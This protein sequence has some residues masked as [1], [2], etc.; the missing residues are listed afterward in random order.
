MAGAPRKT[1]TPADD[2]PLPIALTTPIPGRPIAPSLKKPA[3]AAAARVSSF[4]FWEAAYKGDHDALSRLAEAEADRDAPRVAPAEE[5]GNA[6]SAHSLFVSFCAGAHKRMQLWTVLCARKPPQS[7]QT[8]KSPHLPGSRSATVG[9]QASSATPLPFAPHPSASAPAPASTSGPFAASANAAATGFAAASTSQSASLPTR[10]DARTAAKPQLQPFTADELACLWCEEVLVE[11][12]AKEEATRILQAGG[13]LTPEQI[14]SVLSSAQPGTG[15]V[16]GV[17]GGGGGDDDDGERPLQILVHLLWWLQHCPLW[18]DELRALGQGLSAAI[19]SGLELLQR[20]ATIDHE[21]SKVLEEGIALH[22]DLTSAIMLCTRTPLMRRNAALG[23]AGLRPSEALLAEA[24]ACVVRGTCGAPRLDADCASPEPCIHC[25][26]SLAEVETGQAEVEGAQAPP[27]APGKGA[28]PACEGESRPIPPQQAA[29][30]ARVASERVR[31]RRLTLARREMLQ[32]AKAA[33]WELCAVDEGPS[34]LPLLRAVRNAPHVTQLPPA[35]A[36]VARMCREVVVVS[37][38]LDRHFR[39]DAGKVRRLLKLL[40]VKTLVSHL[41][42]KGNADRIAHSA[43]GIMVSV[44]LGRPPGVRLNMAQ[45]VAMN[46]P[47][48]QM[49]V[50]RSK[51]TLDA[52]PRHT[53]RAVE[54]VL[55]AKPLLQCSAPPRASASEDEDE[56]REATRRALKQAALD[57]LG[58][59][60]GAKVEALLLAELAR[61]SVLEQAAEAIEAGRDLHGRRLLIGLYATRDFERVVRCL[62]PLAYIPWIRLALRGDVSGVSSVILSD[63]DALLYT[64]MSKRATDQEVRQAFRRFADA[65]VETAYAFVRQVVSYCDEGDPSDELCG[66]LSWALDSLATC[67]VTLEAEAYIRLGGGE[68]LRRQLCAAVAREHSGTPRPRALRLPAASLAPLVLRFEEELHRGV[69][70]LHGSGFGTDRG[71]VRITD[72]TV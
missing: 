66:V 36:E 58:S 2:K 27:L 23:R 31:L 17:G 7:M 71:M 22:G 60:G 40:P 41:A 72:L 43:F 55:G 26:S 69:L 53:R 11:V 38:D 35:L 5:S 16:G 1:A 39:R 32:A 51:A 57:R 29:L 44:L 48:L 28:C 42:R 59:K 54:Q 56:G 14:E 19:R 34:P 15:S 33:M 6:S 9:M 45:R 70:A 67:R 61:P 47:E 64:A 10:Q 62:C 50:H 24:K 8:R 49:L 21:A 12:L 3:R 30:H 52:L 63:F 46:D 13:G 65:L 25:G 20:M 4:A 18:G 37:L 68:A